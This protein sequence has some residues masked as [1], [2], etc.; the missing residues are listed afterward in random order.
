M[1]GRKP[2]QKKLS[3]GMF[4]LRLLL[5]FLLRLSIMLGL[6]IELVL[7]LLAAERILLALIRAGGRALILVDL[8]S[9]NRIF[10]RHR[11]P[12]FPT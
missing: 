11:K 6:P 3:V 2:P 12:L 5:L 8:H 10:R 1:S 9:T 4:V 7:A